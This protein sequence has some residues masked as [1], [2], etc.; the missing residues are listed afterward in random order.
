[1]Q[2]LY[3]GDEKIKLDFFKLAETH[4]HDIFNSVNYLYLKN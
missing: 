4:I 3:L 1:M 2:L